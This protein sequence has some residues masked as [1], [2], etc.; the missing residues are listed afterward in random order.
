VE[1]LL[2]SWCLNK[3]L[4]E[5]PQ[6]TDVSCRLVL[7]IFIYG[8]CKLCHWCTISVAAAPVKR[9]VKVD[10]APSKPASQSSVFVFKGAQAAPA[11]NGQTAASRP[12]GT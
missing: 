11:A 7:N 10:P 8:T 9:A 5:V 4:K 6:L 1:L 12:A 2:Q 3:I